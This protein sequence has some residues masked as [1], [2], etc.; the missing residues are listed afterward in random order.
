MLLLAT[1]DVG[2]TPAVAQAAPAPAQCGPTF[3]NKLSHQPWP[4]SR[5][6]PSAA[7]PLSRGQHVTVA[8][9]DSGVSRTHP[10]MAGQV[11]PGVDFVKPGGKGDC[12]EDGHGTLVAGIIAARDIKDS[13]FSGV[14]PDARILPVRVLPDSKKYSD[15][16][17]PTRI[18]QAIR[19]AVRQGAD[20]INLSLTTDDTPQVRSAV[21]YA[22]D[23]NVVVV[24][25]AGNEGGA[26]QPNKPVYPA[27]YP[28]VLGV[29]GID[30]QGRH[31]SSSNVGWYVDV[32]APGYAI[33]G[34]APR[35]D[36]YVLDKEGGTSFAAAYV[37][38]VAALVRG[39]NPTMRASDVVRRIEITADAP[40]GGRNNEVGYGVVNPYQAVATVLEGVNN[41]TVTATGEMPPI[42]PDTDPLGAVK[43]VAGWSFLVSLFV[44][45]LLL[46]ARPVIRRGRARGWLPAVGATDPGTPARAAVP[47]QR[48]PSTQGRV[49]G[50]AAVRP[51]S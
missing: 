47:R 3:H 50:R 28:G 27:A 45:V 13:W 14:A 22:V 1:L 23:H 12:D 9:I 32:A 24:A 26:H 44:A 36:G 46:L 21:E 10:Q 31:V 39:Y 5:L 6:Q 30:Q 15:P 20:V 19:Y 48:M 43:V 49:A 51:P 7:W 25:A 41:R 11:L 29:A 2:L 42:K 37:S 17:L 8:V 40:A 16:T 33:E 34:P 4:L 35:G 18:A 38:G